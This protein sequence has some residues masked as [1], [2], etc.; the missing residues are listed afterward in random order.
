MGIAATVVRPLGGGDRLGGVDDPAA[1]E[2]DE[3][4]GADLRQKRRGDLVDASGGDIDDLGRAHR[5][6]EVRWSGRG[7]S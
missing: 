7:G 4:A 5:E 6:L 3:P 1:A 2:G